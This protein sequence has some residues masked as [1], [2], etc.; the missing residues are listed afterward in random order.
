MKKTALLFAGQGAQKVGMGRDLADAFPLA[1]ALF[2]KADDI[3]GCDLSKIIWEGPTEMLTNTT[4]CQPAI[5]LV[6][7][8][9]LQLLRT[10]VPD[11]QFHATAGLSLGEFT[12]LAA[13]DAFSFEDGL[14]LVRKRGAYMQEACEC[15]QGEMAAILGMDEE[16]V[17]E[18][19]MESGAEI[20]NLNCPGQ[21]V[22]SGEKRKIE[23]ACALARTKGAKKVIPLVV[24]GA[25]HSSLMGNVS[26]KLRSELEKTPISAPTVPVFSNVTAEPH[27]S[28]AT[29]IV[30]ILVRQV[31]SS[32]FFEKSLKNLID[33]GVERF[34]EIGPGTVLSGFLKRISKD[35]ETFHIS[36]VVSL[37]ETVNAIK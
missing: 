11:F 13:A 16:I 33:S 21:I 34:I 36:D 4:Y 8:V 23:T 12:A 31:T 37:Q 29:E 30:D 6:S 5:Y 32:V 28:S 35:V 26:A 18:V 2:A 25:Y 7:W 27:S 1:S 24:A 19:C 10:Q 20:A 22:I 17:R 9:G 15:T 14:R 3:L